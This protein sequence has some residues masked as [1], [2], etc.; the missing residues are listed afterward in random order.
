MKSR[1]YLL[2]QQLQKEKD[3]IKKNKS[4]TKDA[5]E[6]KIEVHKINRYVKITICQKSKDNSEEKR[7]L[8][9]L[10]LKNQSMRLGHHQELEDIQKAIYLVKLDDAREAKNISMRHRKK[11]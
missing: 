1:L 10:R 5:I 7:K 4:M 11:I 8:E 3:G 6:K 9:E 2:R